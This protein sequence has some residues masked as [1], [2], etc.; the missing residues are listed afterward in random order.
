MKVVADM[1]VHTTASDGMLS[2][3]EVVK[4]AAKKGLT[5]LAITDHDTVDGIQEAQAVG[6]KMGIEIWPGVE[7]STEYHDKEIHL[8]GLGIEPSSNS[9]YTLLNMLRESRFERMKK[10]VTNLRGMG[11]KICMEE[12]LQQ[13]GNAAPGRP[14]VARVLVKKGYMASVSEAFA[15]LLERGLPAY[16]ERYKL[17]PKAA[18]AAIRAAGG[19]AC[20]AHPGLVK[21]DFLLTTFIEN[22]LQGLEVFHSDHSY[23]EEKKYLHLAQQYKLL[24]SGGSDFHGKEVDRTR[25]LAAFGLNADRYKNFKQLFHEKQEN[26]F[27][28]KSE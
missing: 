15:T 22:G 8:L 17:S 3:K 9:L 11:Y 24:I 18:I 7:L 1:H 21:E 28:F 13:A 16:V 27:K 6:H 12:V 4:L 14:H 2:P 23:S 19:V 26:N 20:W 10:I 25:D 5:A